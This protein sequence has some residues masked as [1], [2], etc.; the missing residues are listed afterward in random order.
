MPVSAS[1]VL[2]KQNSKTGDRVLVRMDNDRGGPRRFMLLFASSDGQTIVSCR[3]R[4]YKI[5]PDVDVSD[6]GPDQY[7]KWTRYPKQDHMKHRL[8]IKSYSDWVWGD[9]EKS[10]LASVVTPQMFSNRPK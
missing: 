6:F 10:I 5:V 7:Q 1:I 9:L 4:D 3:S 8:P 2:Q